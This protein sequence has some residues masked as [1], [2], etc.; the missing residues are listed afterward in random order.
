MATLARMF[1]PSLTDF[2]RSSHVSYRNSK[3][4][5]MLQPSLSGDSKVSVICTMNPSA[6]AYIPAVL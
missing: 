2:S 3:L 1:S 5:R 6:Q 4:T